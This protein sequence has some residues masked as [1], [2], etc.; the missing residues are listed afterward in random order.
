MSSGQNRVRRRQ[1]VAELKRLR[2]EAGLTQEEVARQLDWHHTKVF[3]IET[4]RTA[5]HPN[6]VRVMCA[7]YGVTDEEHL[8][9]PVQLAKESRKRGWWY[10]YRDVLPSRYEFIIGLE[11]EAYAIHTFQLAVV[12]GLLQTEDYAMALG[13]GGPLE[14]DTD[15]IRRRVEVRMN[16]Q[17][18]LDKPDRP[19][20]WAIIDEAA[21]HRV[22]G[23][24][25]V[26]LAQLEHLITASEA[27]KTTIQIV[28]YTVGA[29]P[30]ICGPFVILKF[31]EPSETDVVY[32]ETIGGSISLDKP[33]E[34]RNYVN[35]FDHLRAVAL[36]PQD[37][38]TMLIRAAKSLA[39]G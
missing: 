15:E 27:G 37:T 32:M 22:V 16:R 33:E 23:G 2:E 35:A 25:K 3:R 30:G 20:L 36:S 26:M 1:L 38:R 24:P 13:K 39:D 34:I 8:A 19:Q 18:V 4:G 11:E 28:P 6:D 5:P 29:H 14:L 7:L 17:R 31:E 21:I 9:A 10:A 12:P